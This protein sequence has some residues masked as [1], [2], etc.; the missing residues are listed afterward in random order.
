MTPLEDYFL[1]TVA[2]FSWAWNDKFFLETPYGNYVWSDPDYNGDN[3]IRRFNGTRKMFLDEQKIPY[4][5]DK[6][7]HVIKDYCGPNVVIVGKL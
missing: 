7:M 2:D 6:G 1:N 4:V 3:T 5:R